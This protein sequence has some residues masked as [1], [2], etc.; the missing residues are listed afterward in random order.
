MEGF[1]DGSSTL[2]ASTIKITTPFG[3]VIFMD[4]ERDFTCSGEIKLPCAKVLAFGQN[5]WGAALAASG[6]MP[7]HDRRDGYV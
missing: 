5:A 4:T 7:Q 3:V 2:P 1:S 6:P